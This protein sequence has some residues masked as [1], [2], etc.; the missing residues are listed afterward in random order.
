[1]AYAAGDFSPRSTQVGQTA[2]KLNLPKGNKLIFKLKL[3]L[4]SL[5][6]HSLPAFEEHSNVAEQ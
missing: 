5:N 4:D 2:P 1:M 6:L 3:V